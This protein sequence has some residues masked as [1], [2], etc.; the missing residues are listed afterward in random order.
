MIFTVV[1][2]CL[3]C[4]VFCFGSFLIGG[5]KKQSICYHGKEWKVILTVTTCRSPLEEIRLKLVGM[6][7]GMT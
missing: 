7:Q 1:G 3:V 2:M 4:L 5:C 6:I